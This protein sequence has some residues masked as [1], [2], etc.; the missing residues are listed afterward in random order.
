MHHNCKALQTQNSKE[1]GK[2]LFLKSLF[3]CGNLIPY[4]CSLQSFIHVNSITVRS[5]V[6]CLAGC[7]SAL[8]GTLVSSGGLE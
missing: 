6:K 4:S 3:A 1:I 5:Q 2:N 8:P 7:V